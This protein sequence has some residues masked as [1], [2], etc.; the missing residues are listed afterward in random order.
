MRYLGKL[1][2][3]GK[4]F[5]GFQRLKEKRSVQAEVE[6]ALSRLGKD[7]VTIHGAGRTDAGVHATGQTFT[8][9][10]PAIADLNEFAAKLNSLL[11]PDIRA[12]D[13]EER[14]EGFDARHHCSGKAYR[15]RFCY[16]ERD[17]FQAGLLAQISGKDFDPSK[18]QS[19]LNYFVG[20]HDFRNFTTKKLDPADFVRHIERIDVSLDEERKRGEVYFK[21]DAFMTYMIRLIMGTAFRA[22]LGKIAPEEIPSLLEAK[23]RH[24]QPFKA[25]AE[26]LYLEEVFYE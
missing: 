9:D 22:C 1:S 19:A 10:F 16:G 20:E 17:P 7:A 11:P 24:I 2:Y 8:F 3:N 15:Y 18:L 21:G 6:R 4:D 26:G 13:L 25:P 23:P 14:P 12:Y 5:F